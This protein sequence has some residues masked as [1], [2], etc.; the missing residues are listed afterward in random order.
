MTVE[1]FF[2]IKFADQPDDN[3]KQVGFQIGDRQDKTIYTE[4]NHFAFI[5][6]L[7]QIQLLIKI[8]EKSRVIQTDNK[9]NSE[10]TGFNTQTNEDDPGNN[11]KAIKY[12]FVTF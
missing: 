3:I 2:Q 1:R 12:K 6:H 5:I 10:C 4:K 8:L 11:M 7:L 9:I